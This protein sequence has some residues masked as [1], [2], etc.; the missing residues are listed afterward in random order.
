MQITALIIFPINEIFATPSVQKNL[1]LVMS[2]FKP[3]SGFFFGRREYA[4]AICF[5]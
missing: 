1:L 4:F 2:R 5:C 3:K